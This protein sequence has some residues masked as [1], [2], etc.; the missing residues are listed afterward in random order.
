MFVY[1][2]CFFLAHTTWF[3]NGFITEMKD[4]DAA[5]VV[6]RS[7]NGIQAAAWVGPYTVRY[8]GGTTI[9]MGKNNNLTCY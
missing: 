2:F 8:F 3:S 1:A 9:C 7:Y 6:N 4:M 5:V